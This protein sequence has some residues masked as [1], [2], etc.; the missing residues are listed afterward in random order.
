[1]NKQPNIASP[2]Q[3]GSDVWVGSHSVILSGICI[4]DGA[5][6]AAGSVVKKD[7]PPYTIVGGTPATILG[8]RK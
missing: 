7:V 6:I 5:I 4:G 2:V 8:K 3:I 1:M